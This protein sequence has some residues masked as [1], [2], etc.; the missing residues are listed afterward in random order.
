MSKFALLIVDLQNAYFNNDALRDQ[1][2]KLLE[3]TNELI[4]MA[5][6][7]SMPIFNI[8]TEHQ[9]DIATWTLNMIDDDSGYLFAGDDDAQNI[10]GLQTQDSIEVIKTRDSAFYGT[11]LPIMLKNH[12]VDTMILCGV[13]THTC[14]FQTAS[15]AYAANFRIILAIDAIATH[16][17]KYHQNALT[18]LE[19]E[20]RQRSMNLEKLKDYIQDNRQQNT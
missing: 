20:Y 11:T 14:I 19:T 16:D 4:A 5:H 1:Q 18:I 12:S 13:S 15:D 9:K 8:K 10:D 17:P 6:A 2:S 3:K 7:Y